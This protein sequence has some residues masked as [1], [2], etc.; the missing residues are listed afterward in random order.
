MEEKL[1]YLV[2]GAVAIVAVVF[3][4]REQSHRNSRKGFNDLVRAVAA[5]KETGQQNQRTPMPAASTSNDP[6]DKP[7]M[8]F[9][10]RAFAQVALMRANNIDID[11]HDVEKR[12]AEAELEKGCTVHQA[13]SMRWGGVQAIHADLAMYSDSVEVAQNGHRAEPYVDGGMAYLAMVLHQCPSEFQSFKQ[14]LG[15]TS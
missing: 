4:F 12:L 7:D 8:Y 2:W 6:S 13:L 10:G 14:Y 1:E 3:I 11:L 9:A 5:S 15:A